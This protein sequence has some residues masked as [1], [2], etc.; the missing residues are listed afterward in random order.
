[1]VSNSLI[2]L[3][4]KF[5]LRATLAQIPIKNIF[6]SLMSLVDSYWMFYVFAL[7][8]KVVLTFDTPSLRIDLFIDRTV[9]I[10]WQHAFKGTVRVKM[11]WFQ[12]K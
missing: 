2:Y 5:S 12:F 3:I 7:V 1:M 10:R 9:K 11:G 6:Q 8:V 4:S